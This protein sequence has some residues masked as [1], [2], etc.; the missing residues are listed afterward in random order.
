MYQP[1]GQ[2]SRL[3][4]L[5]SVC[6]LAL[7]ADVSSFGLL[8]QPLNTNNRQQD[9]LRLVTDLFVDSFWQGKV[10]GGANE[11]TESQSRTLQSQQY[12]EFRKR[13]SRTGGALQTQLMLCKDTRKNSAIIGCAGVQVDTVTG[14]A[15]DYRPTAGGSLWASLLGNDIPAK[16]TG[17]WKTKMGYA[18][19]MSNLV[20]SRQYRRKGIAEKLVED[21]E[22]LCQE[23]G[24][25]ECFLYVEK[26]NAPAVK[27]YQKLGYKT[28]WQDLKAK[29]LVPTR[30]GE[31]E[32]CDTVIICMK[33]EL[34]PKKK[35]P[36]FWPFS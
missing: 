14:F 27:L 3:L 34:K 28:L 32:N 9:E 8:N 23:W 24:Y 4:A 10:G 30:K 12:S 15:D 2:R 36:S 7:V 22:E 26:R 33:K 1:C 17:R 21:V 31:L 16:P 18:P 20:V 19:I 29:T 6:L 13:Y 5:F 35:G 25:D 11:L